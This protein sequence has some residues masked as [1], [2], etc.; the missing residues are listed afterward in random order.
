M[1]KIN[2]IVGPTSSGKTSLAVKLCKKYG[3]QIISADSRQVYKYMDIGTGKVPV[4][5][6]ISINKSDEVWELNG[7]KVWGYDLAKPDEYFSSYD[8]NAW[9]L[10]KAKELVEEGNNIFLVGGTGFYI[11]MF[12]KRIEPSRIPPDFELRKKLKKMDLTKLKKK[13]TS[14]NLEVFKNIDQN[15]PVRLIRAIEKELNEKKSPP[16][17]YFEDVDFSYIGLTSSNE[18]LYKRVDN[19]TEEIWNNGLIEETEKLIELGYKNS[20]PLQGLVYK[21]VIDYLGGNM[22]EKQAIQRIK[23]DLHSYIRRQKTYFDKNED[24]KWFDID[25]EKLFQ[26]VLDNVELN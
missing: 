13:L 12:T 17:P 26:K 19:W 2:V 9:A 24:I 23:F 14:L 3:G 4:T 11:D 10:P 18:N 22:A 16:L 6:D 5:K 25:D 20:R 7:V 15:N 21:T 1:E 8:F